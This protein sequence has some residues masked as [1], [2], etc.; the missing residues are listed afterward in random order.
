METRPAFARSSARAPSIE[1]W[2]SNPSNLSRTAGSIMRRRSGIR[3]RR[4]LVVRL[5]L[6]AEAFKLRLLVQIG[7]AGAFPNFLQNRRRRIA[8][9]K[10]NG[11]YTSAR[12]FHFLP[13]NNLVAGPIAA[14]Y[15]NIGKQPGNHLA[16]RRF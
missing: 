2:R 12:R 5:R 6:L 9:H 1:G 14:F 8:R 3:A 15:K 16:R 13:A 4:A 11:N 7:R 10:W